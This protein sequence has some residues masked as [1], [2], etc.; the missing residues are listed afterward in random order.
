MSV[1]SNVAGELLIEIVAGAGAVATFVPVGFDKTRLIEVLSIGLVNDVRVAL[2]GVLA[3]FASVI[4]LVGIVNI[5]PANVMPVFE[6]F[7]SSAKIFEKLGVCVA[8][9]FTL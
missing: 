3:V 2:I 8:A 9:K 4:V 1:V 7:E 6:L 5:P